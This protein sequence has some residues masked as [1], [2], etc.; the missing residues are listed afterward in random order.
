MY[1]YIDANFD[2]F[3]KVFLVLLVAGLFTLAIA[4]FRHGNGSYSVSNGVIYFERPRGNVQWRGQIADIS[5]VSGSPDWFW[6]KW[7]VVKFG[8]RKRRV[9]LL[10]SL[11][12][13]LA[14][15][16]PPNNSFERTREG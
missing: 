16:A 8:D 15:T 2:P 6:E 3:L 5:G 11:L 10:P 9:E 7:I 4:L 12:E 1:R 14:A 13:A